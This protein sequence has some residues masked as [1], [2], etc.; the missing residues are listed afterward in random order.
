MILTGSEIQKRIGKE[1]CIEPF[2][3]KQLNPNSYNLRLHNEIMIYDNITYPAKEDASRKDIF[4]RCFDYPLDTK[5]NNPTQTILIPQDGYILYPGLIYLA[6]TIEY[7]KTNGLVP[8]INGRSS[9]GRLGLNIHA[10]AGFGDIG[11]EGYWTLELFCIHPVIIYPE[12]Q[13]CQI[14][15]QSVL[16]DI[17]NTYHG[18]YQ[19]NTD[20]QASKM[21]EELA[22]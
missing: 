1:I 7:T 6:R 8:V 2:N 22:I 17:K 15:Y 9:L 11:F 12:I 16:G 14:S 18:K 4:L 13:I 20:I 21:Y 5:K 10:T 19:H 3:E